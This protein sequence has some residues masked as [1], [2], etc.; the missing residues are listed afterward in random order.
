MRGLFCW[1][2]DLRA[3][4]IDLSIGENGDRPQLSCHSPTTRVLTCG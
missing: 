2:Q 1:F 3:G 4:L